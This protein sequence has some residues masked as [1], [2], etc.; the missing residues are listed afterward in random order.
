MA[1]LIVS[2]TPAAVPEYAPKLERMSGA[3]D[4]ALAEHVGT[5]RTVG[6]E[7]S[8]RLL[9]DDRAI[10]RCGA[11]GGRE[12]AAV[13]IADEDA[14]DDEAPADGAQPASATSPALSPVKPSSLSIR[15]RSSSVST[16]NA[17]PWS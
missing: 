11:G 15:R 3:H 12:A 13:A 6:R 7:R 16:S 14:A 8:G 4:A 10:G 17:R 2:G 5:V 9:G 1:S